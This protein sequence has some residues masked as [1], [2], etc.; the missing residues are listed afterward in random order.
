MVDRLRARPVGLQAGEDV[1]Y[2]KSG[3][4]NQPEPLYCGECSVC[5]E[6][7]SSLAP[8]PAWPELQTEHD[9]ARRWGAGALPGAKSS[10]L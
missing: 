3:L 2:T 9:F 10:F 1:K 5:R 6:A 8:L 7:E 4:R